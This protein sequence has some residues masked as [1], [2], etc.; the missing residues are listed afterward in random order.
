[1]VT[2]TTTATATRS[3]KGQQQQQQHIHT[4]IG[5]HRNTLSPPSSSSLATFFH[6]VQRLSL[7]LP[8]SPLTCNLCTQECILFCYLMQRCLYPPHSFIGWSCYCSDYRY[9]IPDCRQGFH[10]SLPTGCCQ[11]VLSLFLFSSSFLFRKKCIYIGQ[12]WTYRIAHGH[13]AD[14]NYIRLYFSLL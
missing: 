13:H 2:T 10:G 1:M 8:A 9:G 4:A 14:W 12:L 7:R 5:T 6:G 11:Y 3:N